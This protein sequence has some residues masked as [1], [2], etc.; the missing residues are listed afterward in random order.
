MQFWLFRNYVTIFSH[1]VI[2]ASTRHS[3]FQ[4]DL[5]NHSFYSLTTTLSFSPSLSL[6][7]MYR[8]RRSP[9]K[10]TPPE[11]FVI[12]LIPMHLGNT[13]LCP[14]NTNCSDDLC[15]SHDR[16]DSA[17]GSFVMCCIVPVFPA[18]ND[19]TRYSAG[20]AKIAIRPPVIKRVPQSARIRSRRN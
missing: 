3:Y 14:R 11:T 2:S 9:S 12:A 20:P 17:V 7:T 4:S 6:V 5:H 19:F 8:R 15:V 13:E 18:A 16:D 10:E 1:Y